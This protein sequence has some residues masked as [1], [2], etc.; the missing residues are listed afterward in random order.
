MYLVNFLN[1][2]GPGISILFVVFV[3]AVAVCWL[4]G[5]NRFSSD[6]ERMI[7]HRP[8]IFWRVCWNYIT[9]VF[10][11]VRTILKYV[12]I[13]NLLVNLKNRYSFVDF[14]SPFS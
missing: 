4:Y 3:E 11:L 6:V 5:V 12:I 10:I 14:F 2:Y 13:F 8:N 7:G 1:I 9:P